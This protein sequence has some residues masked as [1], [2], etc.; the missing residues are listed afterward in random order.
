MRGRVAAG[1]DGS[2]VAAPSLGRLIPARRVARRTYAATTRRRG[3]HPIGQLL[4]GL[5]VST[6]L[7]FDLSLLS[8]SIC[9]AYS[10]FPPPDLPATPHIGLWPAGAI[11]ASMLTISG[12]IFGLHERETIMSRSRIIT[13]ITLTAG[14]ATV[15]A[16]AIIYVLMYA[17]VSR[18]VTG[19][20]MSAFVVIGA[21][22]RLGAWWAIHRVHRGLLVVGPRCLYDSFERAQANGNL[23][24]YRL[25]GYTVTDNDA[26]EAAYEPNCLGPIIDQV[27]R[28]SELMVTDIVV[29]AE[30]ASDARVMDWMVPC[31]QRGCRVTNEAIFYEKA[32]GQILVNEITPLW[33]LFADLKVNCDRRAILKRAVDL[34]AAVVGFCVFAPVCPLIA[35]AI[36]LCDGGPV[37]YSQDRVGQNGPIFKLYK[38]RTMRPDA[39]NGKSVWASP[40]DPRVTR[41]GRLLRKSRLDEL[42]QLY[43]VL[44]GQMSIIGPRPERPDIVVDLCIVLPYYAERH[45]V[46]PGITG[47]AQIS[48]RYGASIEDARR[49]LQ[50]D[51]YYLKHMSFEL[52]LMILF[53]T[54]GTF[55]RGAC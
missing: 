38:F 25:V 44:M 5:S 4:V 35:L 50:Y 17:T 43:N 40:D 11:F 16:Y 55:V 27:S 45:L 46:K 41:V 36:K 6:W 29:G 54:I 10:Q 22:A 47:W 39:E 21:G 18:R 33:F 52:D 13:R 23:N 3:P 1:A 48:F 26:A 24:E 15:M 28:L 14:T 2:S 53:R 8:V 9:F 30:A 31:L 37:F 20:T 19:V 32:T 34:I 12:L 42:P 51:L 7:L 49:K